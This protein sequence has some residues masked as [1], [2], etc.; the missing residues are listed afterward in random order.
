MRRTCALSCLL[1]GYSL[2]ASP[3]QNMYTFSLEPADGHIVM[4]IQ[5]A[6]P[7]PCIGYTIRNR[8]QWEED[9]MV[10]ILNGFVRPIPCVEGL[11]PAS[12]RIE[13][14]IKSKKVFY[15]K[16]LEDTFTDLW[17]I[18]AVES[19]F[20]ALPVRSMFTSYSK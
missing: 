16:F 18:S 5:T 10:V 13:A 20:R 4:T 6:E 8:V 15:L 3:Q 9:T 7:L 19:G 14:H 2:S 11:E 17:E 12:A 1:L